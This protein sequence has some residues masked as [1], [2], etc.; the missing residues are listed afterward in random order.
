MRAQLGMTVV[1]AGTTSVL[2]WCSPGCSWWCAFSA[3]V[4]GGNPLQRAR[5]SVVSR[6]RVRGA[7]CDRRAFAAHACVRGAAVRVCVREY[8]VPQCAPVIWRCRSARLS[9]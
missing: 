8:E 3:E 5:R 7:A 6:A 2:P 9:S 4:S 1:K